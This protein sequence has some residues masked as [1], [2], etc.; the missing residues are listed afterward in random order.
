MILNI[1]KRKEDEERFRNLKAHTDMG[2]CVYL[3]IRRK[4]SQCTTGY[5]LLTRAWPDMSGA[6]VRMLSPFLRLSACSG[7]A[8]I[9][10]ILKAWRAPLV[11]SRDFGSPT[12]II[13]GGEKRQTDRRWLF[14]SFQICIVVVLCFTSFQYLN[15]W[16]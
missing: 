5:I 15:R 4:V 13:P 1:T 3:S 9:I 6:V 8:E 12:P 10:G 7:E 16:R 2:V 14:L 11:C